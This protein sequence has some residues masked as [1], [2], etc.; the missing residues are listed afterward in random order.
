MRGIF[1][2]FINEFIFLLPTL[3][4][5]IVV[6]IFLLIYL[7]ITNFAFLKVLII[8]FFLACFFLFLVRKK[9]ISKFKIQKSEKKEEKEKHQKEFDEKKKDIRNKYFYIFLPY[10]AYIFITTIALDDV[11]I[12]FP[13]N[14]IYLPL[15]EADIRPQ[16]FAIFSTTIFFLLYIFLLWRIGDFIY[17]FIG[18]IMENKTAFLKYNFIY[19][20]F[21]GLS[22]LFIFLLIVWKFLKFQEFYF[23]YYMLLLILIIIYASFTIFAFLNVI[24]S[25]IFK[26]TKIREYLFILILPFVLSIDFIISYHYLFKNIIKYENLCNLLYKNQ[27]SYYKKMKENFGEAFSKKQSIQISLPNNSS[28]NF[29]KEKNIYPVVRFITSW[30]LNNY[31]LYPNKHSLDKIPI[32]WEKIKPKITIDGLQEAKVPDL[33]K[34]VDYFKASKELDNKKHFKNNNI[35]FETL[36]VIDIQNRSLQYIEIKNVFIPKLKFYKTNLAFSR[37]K[38]VDFRDGWFE[39]VSF[40]NASI[41]ECNFSN[42]KFVNVIFK[43]ASFKDTIFI[44]SFIRNTKFEK[45]RLYNEN[46]QNATL[47]DT[48]ITTNSSLEQNNFFMSKIKLKIDNSSLKSNNFNKS[49]IFQLT[50]NKSDLTRNYFKQSKIIKVKIKNSHLKNIIFYKSTFEKNSSM[51]FDNDIL[52]NIKFT[53]IKIPRKNEIYVKISNSILYKC[54]FWKSNFK[55]EKKEKIEFSNSIIIEPMF[56][57]LEPK[58]FKNSIVIFSKTN[59]YQKVPKRKYI[60]QEKKKDKILKNLESIKHILKQEIHYYINQLSDKENYYYCVFKGK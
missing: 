15:V 7:L 47:L 29:S 31:F 54:N 24:I 35:N 43:N 36:P 49:Q 56:L 12:L 4:I 44:K 20:L 25:I 60:C 45:T 40:S 42:S 6:F 50:I 28:S 18:I 59:K 26:S 38:K 34:I 3:F 46:F 8:S 51:I 27:I 58:R 19:L 37:F 16:D 53:K 48:E 11:T 14:G 5:F 22:P 21:F 10:M 52:E 57:D 41:E 13:E 33:K 32:S 55:G 39:L 1:D 2:S 9:L 30:S 23:F 17:T